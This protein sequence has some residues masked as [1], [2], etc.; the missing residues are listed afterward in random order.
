MGLTEPWYEDCSKMD[1]KAVVIRGTHGRYF[2]PRL[3]DLLLPACAQHATNHWPL[4]GPY[5]RRLKIG[6]ETFNYFLLEIE[7][8]V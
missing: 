2:D 1:E 6:L 5:V 8:Q 7:V 3:G 4:L